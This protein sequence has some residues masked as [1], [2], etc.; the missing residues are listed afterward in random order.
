MK[1]YE[2][3]W[4]WYEDYIHFTF[5]HPE[6]KSEEEFKAD[7]DS[8]MIKYGEDY[9]E[10]EESWAGANGWVEYIVPKMKELGYETPTQTTYGFWGA[11]IIES[12]ADDDKKFGDV[13]GKELLEKA[14][15]HNKKIKEE[16]HEN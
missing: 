8:L 11:Y 6:N 5:C 2:L 10:S 4:S 1:I 15:K 14:I 16:M 13:V 7:V 9:L 12:K 3:Y